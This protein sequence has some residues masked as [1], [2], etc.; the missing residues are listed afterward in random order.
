MFVFMPS[1]KSGPAHKLALPYKGPYRIIRLYENG[2][3]VQLIDCPRAQPI[4]VAL[5]R[6]RHYPQCG[7]QEVDAT[8]N[9]S[10]VPNTSTRDV[11]V[12]TQDME[13]ITSSCNTDAIFQDTDQSTPS[14]DGEVDS[15]VDTSQTVNTPSLWKS[16][17][18]PRKTGTCGHAG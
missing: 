3:D 13:E 11:E 9:P 16:R 8:N 14:P 17:L 10:A 5:N 7:D 4:R 18:R 1:L 15:E 12:A 2:A 6:L